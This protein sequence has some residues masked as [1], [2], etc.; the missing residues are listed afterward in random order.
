M[1]DD[2]TPLYRQVRD[3]HLF[4]DVPVPKPDWAA[5]IANRVDGW[6]EDRDPQA[7]WELTDL[8]G[9]E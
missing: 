3:E 1:P 8:D 2:D 9:R 6:C 4:D 7:D 5:L